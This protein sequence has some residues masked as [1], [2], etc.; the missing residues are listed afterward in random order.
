MVGRL[1]GAAFC[2]RFLRELC[3]ASPQPRRVPS[4]PLAHHAAIRA[5]AEAGARLVLRGIAL[6]AVLAAVKFAGGIAGRSHALVADA[7]E[8]L[9]DIFSSL[10]VWT[11][12]RVAAE[13]PDADHP[14]GHGKAEPLAALAVAVFVFAASA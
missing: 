7:V 14:Y 6:N 3:A 11:G 12:F 5:R 10:L 13:P 4:P 9:L 2:A 8:S 1:S